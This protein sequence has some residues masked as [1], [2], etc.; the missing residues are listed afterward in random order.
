MA[1]QSDG[2]VA[3]VL[4]V[5]ALAGAAVATI[6]AVA[7]IETRHEVSQNQAR[8][9]M[10]QLTVVNRNLARTLEALEPGVSPQQAREADR[11]AAALSRTLADDVGT[12]GDLGAG[13][14]AVL[15]AE[16][17]YLD[18]IGSTLNNPRSRLRQ[19]IGRRAIALR[20]VLQNV[21]G[22]A[23]SDVRGGAALVAYSSARVSAPG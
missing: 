7:S 17:S 13:V 18:A 10:D 21:P 2:R 12:E 20:Q 4:A 16:L 15:G 3:R 23:P 1:T 14:H 8:R 11:S 22:G 19:D 6:I 5:V 9:A